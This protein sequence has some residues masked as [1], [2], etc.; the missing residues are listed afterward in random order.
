MNLDKFSHNG[1]IL[2]ITKATLPLTNIEYQ[3]GF[4]VYDTLRVVKGIPYFRNYHTK[5]LLASAG[6]I[7]LEHQFSEDSINQY[8]T[9]L[10]QAFNSVE[11][12]NLKTLLIGGPTSEEAHLYILPLMPRFPDRKLYRHGANVITV[13]YE[14]PF[15]QAKTLS[16]LRSYLAYKEATN[17][18]CYDAL[19]VGHD[20]KIREGT[21]TNFFLVKR[22]AIYTPPDDLVLDG[23]TRQIVLSLARDNGYEIIYEA[24]TPLDLMNYDGAFLTSTS[25]KIVPIRGI[26][27]KEYDTISP[28]LKLLMNIYDEFLISCK[29]I[30]EG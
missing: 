30:Y 7:G 9:E 18:N 10:A 3:Y 14:R 17:K 22:K 5:R 2:P 19:A 8:V 12:F 25:S 26:D 23:V 27:D 28:N 13:Q 20:G 4:G 11:V 29:G 16:M 24:V 15:P 21:R 1:A 6:M